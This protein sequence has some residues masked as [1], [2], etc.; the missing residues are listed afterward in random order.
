MRLQ[1]PRSGVRIC[2]LRGCVCSCFNW[3]LQKLSTFYCRNSGIYVYIAVCMIQAY[4]SFGHPI[5][6][7]LVISSQETDILSVYCIWFPRYCIFL[8]YVRSSLA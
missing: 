5:C 4:P 1:Q 7:F 2:Q 6:M 8:F 3:S